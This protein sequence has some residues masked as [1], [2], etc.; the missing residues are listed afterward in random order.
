[1]QAGKSIV[2]LAKEIEYRASIK[3]DYVADTREVS[4]Q[5]DGT[6]LTVGEQQGLTLTEHSHR[7]IG[8]RVGI[9]AKYYDRLRE[10]APALL[11]ENVNHW[12]HEKPERRMIR[13]LGDTARAFLSDRYRRIDNEDIAEAVLPILLESSQIRIISTEITERR[14]YIQAIFPRLEGEIRKGD[15]VQSGII[16]SNSEIGQGSFSVSPLVFRLVCENGMI[17]SSALK[18]Y[19]VGR[20][21]ESEDGSLE[22]FRDETL[23]ADDRALFLKVQDVVRS[24]LNE[25]QFEYQIER[26]REAAGGSEIENPVKAVE[27]LAKK[28]GFNDSEGSSILKSLTRAGDYTRY[29][30]IQAVTEQANTAKDYDRAVEFETLG[31]QILDLN[32]SDWRRVAEAA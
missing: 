21:A 23:Q 9:P 31:G 18:K 4:L 7:Q 28:H 29:G 19:H 13:T 12:F 30:L 3:K 26:L 11:A 22:I 25:A 8:D 14:L 20:R 24:S 15:T 10:E 5:T 2:E 17:S 32:S 1:M 16:I 27:V 6:H